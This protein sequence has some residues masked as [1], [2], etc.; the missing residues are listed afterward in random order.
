MVCSE[1]Q[2]TLLLQIPLCMLFMHVISQCAFTL[3]INAALQDMTAVDV[4]DMSGYSI[5]QAPE[6]KMKR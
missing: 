6:L 1:G 5:K 4:V 3:H 2:E